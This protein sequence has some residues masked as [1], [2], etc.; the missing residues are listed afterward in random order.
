MAPEFTTCIFMNIATREDTK[1]ETPPTF[2]HNIM[3]DCL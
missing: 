2:I 3:P 1:Q